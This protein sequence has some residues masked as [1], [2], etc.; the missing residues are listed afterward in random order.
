MK[1][2]IAIPSHNRGSELKETLRSLSQIETRSV[3]D[4]EVLVIGNGCT[5]QT[6]EVARDFAPG[7]GGRL[8]YVGED[9]LGLNHARNRAVS[10]SQFE[11]VALLDDDVEVDRHWLSAVVTAFRPEDYPALGVKPFLIYPSHRPR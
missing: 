5:D 10:E 11:L 8:R 2:S 6:A 4:Y 9:T 1:V 7:F 3:D